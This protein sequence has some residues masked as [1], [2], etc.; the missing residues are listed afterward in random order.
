MK[1]SKRGEQ[2]LKTLM[3]LAEVYPN[4]PLTLKY[5][6]DMTGTSV[7]F[8]EQILFLLRRGKF[9]IS[10]RGNKGGFTLARDPREILVGDAVR[11]L[12][13]P[14]GPL[15]SKEDLESLLQKNERYAGL[16]QKF[17]D[18]RNAASDVL[19]HCNLWDLCRISRE[20]RQSQSGMYYI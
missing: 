3:E 10:L 14:L 12:E 8:L 18:V 13:G 16:Y 2:A 11:F 9:V 19:D 5:I 20:M 1:I 15:G 6:S 4:K 17:L 7:K